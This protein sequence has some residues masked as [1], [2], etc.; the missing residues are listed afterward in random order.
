[1]SQDFITGIV[2]NPEV[3]IY[4]YMNKNTF[5]FTFFS[6]EI[7]TPFETNSCIPIPCQ[8]GFINGK[9]HSN[10]DI[11]IYSGSSKKEIIGNFTLNTSAYIL[12]KGNFEDC[13][14]SHF[15]SIRFEG[16]TL[17]TVF[18]IHG[19]DTEY[20]D[21]S[22]KITHND[23]SIQYSIAI[24]DIIFDIRI[25]SSVHHVHSVKGQSISND[26]VY[27]VLNFKESQSIEKCFDHYN[28]IKDLL[29]FMTFRKDVF[30]DKIELS[31]K[32]SH[33]DTERIIEFAEVF[34]KNDFAKG[35]KNI[36]NNITFNDLGDGFPK[37]LSLLY[38]TKDRKE[39]LSLGFIPKN[40]KKV[41]MIDNIQSRSIC[42]SIECELKFIEDIKIEENIELVKL[43]T[44][45]KRL[46]KDFRNDSNL[47]N[48][49]YDTIFSSIKNW[50]FPLAEKLWALV[51]KYC[52]EVEIMNPS[53]TI[54]NED[55]IKNFVK[56]RNDITHGR[57]R[58]INTE[59]GLVAHIVRGLVYC[60]ILD[61][62]GV[63]RDK[64]LNLCQHTL[65]S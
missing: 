20:T 24:D 64:I 47:S 12:S 31:R 48:G 61:R 38:D 58:I 7:Y 29:S 36:F 1:M 42:S 57:H 11:A 32:T 26:K 25:F 44:S 46:V 10:H 53:T 13:D 43:V 33:G 19:L 35:D 39:S 62:I 15:D 2:N 17:N 59:I 30:F 65:L 4:F 51:E 22:T 60:C 55:M 49:T 56:Y 37:L 18:D 23:D 16:G 63:P 50:S 34:I 8:N 5:Q 21:G 28:K 40:D 3:P 6:N 9:T 14:L 41:N 54:I 52:Q 27:L 45:V